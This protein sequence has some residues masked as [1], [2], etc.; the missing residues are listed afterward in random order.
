M[1]INTLY[2]P[3]DKIRFMYT[4]RHTEPY[5]LTKEILSIHVKVYNNG[6]CD[7]RYGVSTDMGIYHVSEGDVI[8]S[9][10]DA[11]M[12][13]ESEKFK[14]P[15][16]YCTPCFFNMLRRKCSDPRRHNACKNRIDWEKMSYTTSEYIDMSDR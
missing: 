10:T 8:L 7:I 4:A 6:A 11:D 14:F 13:T 9:T 2:K 1:Q 16:C 5:T 12:D 15:S 3:G